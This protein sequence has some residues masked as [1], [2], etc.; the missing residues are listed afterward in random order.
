MTTARSGVVRE[1]ITTSR[2]G[3]LNSDQGA[4]PRR[5]RARGEGIR[6][7]ASSREP[8]AQFSIRPGYQ[9]TIRSQLFGCGQT[10]W[11]KPAYAAPLQISATPQL[12]ELNPAR[13]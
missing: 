7:A 6:K 11:P 8:A 1:L 2:S 4:A 13:R 3:K 12:F 10:C 5:E 9:G